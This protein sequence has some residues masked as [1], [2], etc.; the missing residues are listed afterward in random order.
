MIDPALA[1]KAIEEGLKAFPKFASMEPRIE[2]VKLFRGST[3]QVKFGADSRTEGDPDN[4][5]FEKVVL[6]TF[7]SLAGG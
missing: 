3:L 6:K 4:F 1:T 7:R 5:A 2:E